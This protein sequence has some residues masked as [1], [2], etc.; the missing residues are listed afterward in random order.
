MK[1]LTLSI[2][3]VI[4]AFV[5]VSCNQASNKNEQSSKDTTVVS[6][7]HPAS[8]LKGDDTATTPDVSGTPSGQDAEAKNFSIAPIV[9]DYLSLKNALVSDDDKAAASAGKKLLATLNKMDMKT[10]PADKHKEFMEIFESAKEN[11]EHIGENA[12]KI[13]HQ[14]EHLASL[15][16]DLKD[17]VSLFGTSQTLYQDHCPMFNEGKGAVW[18]SETKEIKNPYYGSKMISCGS[19]KKQY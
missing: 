10:I 1:N 12:G 19:V 8:H 18:L 2:I 7:E 16:E 17:L 5:T 11:A 4:M 6:Q 13:D 14:R 9:T 3:A 15:S